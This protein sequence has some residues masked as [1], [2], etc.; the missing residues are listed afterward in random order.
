MGRNARPAAVAADRA[1]KKPCGRSAAHSVPPVD[2]ARN[3]SIDW[4]A[5]AGDVARALLGEP[6]SATR[7]ELRYGR[8]GS[9]NGGAWATLGTSGLRSVELPECIR[10]VV[11]A[12]DRDA[13][14]GGQL[15][16]AALAER[17]EAEGRHVSIHFSHDFGEFG[18]FADALAESMS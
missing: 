9:W 2:S 15:A 5:I 17:L 4:P 6:S 10:E 12:A 1:R 3:P 7:T 8:R 13:K 11:I 14:G 16:A 18:D